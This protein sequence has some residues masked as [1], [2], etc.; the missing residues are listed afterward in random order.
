M[1]FDESEISVN[2][3]RQAN[4]VR[5]NFLISMNPDVGHGTYCLLLNYIIYVRYL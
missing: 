3:H 5:L 2:L 1:Q 4:R